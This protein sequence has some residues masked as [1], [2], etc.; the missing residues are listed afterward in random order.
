VSREAALQYIRYCVC[1]DV[2]EREYQLEPGT[3]WGKGK[4]CD[5]FGPI[6]PWV[7]PAD[8]ICDVQRLGMWLGVWEWTMRSKSRSVTPPLRTAAANRLGRCTRLGGG[9]GALVPGGPRPATGGVLSRVSA[10]GLNV[11]FGLRIQP[12]NATISLYI[13][14]GVLKSRVFLGRSL[15]FL[16]T[17]FRRACE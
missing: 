4:G 9:D 12:V 6:G 5:T 2:T 14:A 17:V 10:P 8:E 7:V 1:N 11:C 13:S 15:S 16:A 3:Q